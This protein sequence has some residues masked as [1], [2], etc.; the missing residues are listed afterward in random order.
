[1]GSKTER[2]LLAPLL[3]RFQIGIAY[4]NTHETDPAGSSRRSVKLINA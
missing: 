3:V 2:G 1:M 4:A